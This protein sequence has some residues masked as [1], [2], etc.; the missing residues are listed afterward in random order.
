MA[1][2]DYLMFLVLGSIGNLCFQLTL[3]ALISWPLLSSITSQA[4]VFL[5]VSLVI[6]SLSFSRRQPMVM[7]FINQFEDR[8]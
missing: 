7:S 5:G 8:T 6:A 3:H 2:I 4:M 1:V